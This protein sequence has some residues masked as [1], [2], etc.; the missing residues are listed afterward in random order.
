MTDHERRSLDSLRKLVHAPEKLNTYRLYAALTTGE[1][2][3]A[4]RHLLAET[5]DP[6]C[7]PRMTSLVATHL[8]FRQATV[9]Q[10]DD[11]KL[12][13]EFSNVPQAGKDLGMDLLTALHIP[14]RQ[15]LLAHFLDSLDIPNTDGIA[16]DEGALDTAEVDGPQVD[17]ALT[18]AANI[19]DDR[20]ILTYILTLVLEGCGFATTL[21]DSLQRYVGTGDSAQTDEPQRSLQHEATQ[22]DSAPE[23]VEDFTTLD[24][25]LTLTIVNAAQQIDGAL[26]VDQVDDLVEEVIH[27]N[28][29]RHRSYCH[30]GFRDALFDRKLGISGP[31]KNKSRMRWY[32]TGVVQGL[33]RSDRWVDILDLFERHP[34]IRDLGDG[35]DGASHTAAIHIATAL[36]A[37]DRP[38]EVSSFIHS[39]ALTRWSPELF[40]CVLRNATKLLRADR[41]SEAKALFDRLASVRNELAEGPAETE[42]FSD[43]QR[44]QA[45]CLQR[46]G[47]FQNAERVLTG[48]LSQDPAPAP[49][50]QAMIFADLGL[51]EG[52]FRSLV[53][54]KLPATEKKRDTFYAALS[55]GRGYFERGSQLKVFYSSHANMCLGVL[56]LVADDFEQAITRLDNA[57]TAF[58]AGR[59]RY[60]T[61]SLI[62][63]TEL[64][65]GIALILEL[66]NERFQEA[67]KMIHNA[68]HLGLTFPRY[69]LG[70]TLENMTEFGFRAEAGRIGDQVLADGKYEVLDALL[71]SEARLAVPGLTDVLLQRASDATRSSKEQASDLRSALQ[72]LLTHEERHE[73]AASVL[74]RLEDMAIR[75]IGDEEF[76]ALF[77]TPSNWDRVWSRDDALFARVHVLESLGNVAEACVLLTDAFHRHLTDGAIDESDGILDRIRRLGVD[78]SHLEPLELRL[79]AS[80][81][82]ESAPADTKIPQA[83]RVRVLMVGGNEQQEKWDDELREQLRNRAPHVEVIFIRS[84]WSGNWGPYL[85]EF[86]RRLPSV[87]AVVIMRFIRTEFGRQVRKACGNIPWRACSGAGRELVIRRILVAADVAQVKPS[88]G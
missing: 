55:R 56:D 25:Q 68:L 48:L 87:H 45:H 4:A 81:A 76:C 11:N 80:R 61:G 84:G 8:H 79:S 21:T 43:V 18:E 82:Q 40:V 85:E 72:L 26:S 32:W 37:E 70:P 13:T 63:S 39:Q 27:L 10:W 86:R 23:A 36:F 78:D 46:T 59:D 42:L 50:I 77:D 67:A 71:T 66:R 69:W 28:A 58:S 15:K 17:H 51:I 44:R 73:E 3:T 20:W 57:R 35:A 22:A 5:E 34:V 47:E 64:Y 16:D 33:A 2:A 19:A 38:A 60:R 1:R 31:E 41:A 9:R 30:R 74:D 65:L 12:A 88:T 53:D 83:A 29:N 24:N 7:R 52:G 54:V 49:D 62:E 14:G 6:S 75:R